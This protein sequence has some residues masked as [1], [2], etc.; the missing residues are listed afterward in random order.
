MAIAIAES[1]A[2]FQTWDVQILATDISRPAVDQ[3]IRGIYNRRRLGNL[4]L[5]QIGA[6]FTTTKDNLFEV[7]P[8][9]RKMVSFVTMNLAQSLYV[10]RMDCIFCMNVLIYFSEEARHQVIRNFYNCLEPGGY[11]FLGHSE[12]VGKLQVELERIVLGDC[13]LYR[14]P[15]GDKTAPNSGNPS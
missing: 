10:G 3:A 14:K 15:T 5:D 7:K 11:L 4:S 2:S 8:N 6:N 12:T 9:L 13:L 1:V